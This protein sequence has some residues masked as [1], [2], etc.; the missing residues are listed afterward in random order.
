MN[1]TLGVIQKELENKGLF[2]LFVDGK[3]RW[4]IDN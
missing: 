3:K 4:Y 2:C 1:A